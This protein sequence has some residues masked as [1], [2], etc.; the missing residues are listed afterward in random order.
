MSIGQLI[1]PSFSEVIGEL[2]EIAIV[3]K[4]QVV[5]YKIGM[6]GIDGDGTTWGCTE[7]KD[8]IRCKLI[9]QRYFIKNI[10]TFWKNWLTILIP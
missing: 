9:S 4:S 5:V 1:M 2:E 7:M 10:D 8:Y 3:D 6:T